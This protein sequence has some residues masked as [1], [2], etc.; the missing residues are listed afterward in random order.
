VEAF[1][2]KTL[3]TLSAGGFHLNGEFSRLPVGKFEPSQLLLIFTFDLDFNRFGIAAVS[4]SGEMVQLPERPEMV[5]ESWMPFACDVCD[6][7]LYVLNY[8]RSHKSGVELHSLTLDG[9]PTQSALKLTF[10]V[11]GESWRE[12]DWTFADFQLS[13]SPQG[14]YIL[15]IEEKE[16]RRVILGGKE[17]NDFLK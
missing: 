7:R 15:D 2:A 11:V 1:D 12:F 9:R 14:I 6:D 10:W 16:M 4:R 13:A 17:G 3:D 5:L 8:N